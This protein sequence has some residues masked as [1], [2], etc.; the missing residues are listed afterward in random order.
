MLSLDVRMRGMA[1]ERMS[2]RLSAGA[3]GRSW[4]ALGGV[5]AAEA[6]D[7]AQHRGDPVGRRGRG[8][9]PGDGADQGADRRPGHGARELLRHLLLLLPVAHDAS[10]AASTPT[11]IASRATTCP[12]AASPSSR[13]WAWASSTIATWLQAG[14][15][16]HGVSRQ[17]DE[18][19]RA[20]EATRRC[21]AGTSGTASAAGSRTSTT[22]STRTARWWP[23]AHGPRTT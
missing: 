6:C 3:A 21:P 5:L 10:C 1:I 16:P 13:H 4:L 7:T 17:A 19:L 18:R 22:R 11:T 23:T 12:P 9:A 2:G 15:L 14:R 20:R 8:L